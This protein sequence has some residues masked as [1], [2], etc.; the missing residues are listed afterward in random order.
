M[1]IIIRPLHKFTKERIALYILYFKACFTTSYLFYS[2]CLAIIA[3]LPFTPSV[4][5]AFINTFGYLYNLISLNGSNFSMILLA[6]NRFHA[7]FFIFS[8]QH[9]WTKK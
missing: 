4:F 2:S 3:Y 8:Y 1:L 7:V 6:L 5:P 9:V